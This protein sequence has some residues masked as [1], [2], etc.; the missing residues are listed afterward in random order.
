MS[1]ISMPL[2]GLGTWKSEPGKVANAVKV[3]IDCGY[4][5]LDCAYVYGNEGEIGEALKGI[6]SSGKIKREDLFIISKL[7]NSRHSP[8]DVKPSIQ[9]SLSLLGLTYF[10]LYLIH[11]PYAYKP[12]KDL[13]PE[14]EHGRMCC[15][16][17]NYIDT[18]K[19]LEKCVDEGLVKYIGLSNFNSKQ[20]QDV[21][22]NSRIKPANL[23]IEIHP[24][25]SQ[26]K[27]VQFAKKH[28]LTVTA[29]SPLASADRPWIWPNDPTLL[30][31]PQ[32]K[33]IAAK[34]K[35]TPAQ[36]VLRWLLHRNIAVIPKSV[37]PSRI[38]ENF[39]IMDFKLSDGEIGIVNSLDRNFRLICPWLDI[40]GK[41][42]HRDIEAPY[43]P[44]T[45]DIEF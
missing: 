14:D 4:R 5:M 28:G 21:I 20:I 25:F 3:A 16:D 36:V 8:S 43:Y 23:Q 40:D 12:G 38:K 29:Y 30:E 45:D 15:I 9:E 24:Y 42:V 41:R 34:H 26:E 18:W 35:K 7:W 1:Q 27:L 32:L 37:T 44:F 22:D 39:E 6:F 2:I 10:D 19:A 17:I 33:E 31:E 13:F 11:W